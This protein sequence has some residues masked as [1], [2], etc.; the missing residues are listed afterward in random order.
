M[1]SVEFIYDENCPNVERARAVLLKAFSVV[2]Q[3]P[4]WKEWSRSDSNSPDYAQRYGSPSILVNGHDIVASQTLSDASCC[5]IYEGEQ[6][7]FQDVPALETVVAAL[8]NSGTPVRKRGWVTS[9]PTVGAV[10]VPKMVCPSC[11]PALTALASS[12]GISVMEFKPFLTL[13]TFTLL[14]VAVL[15]LSYKARQRRGNGPFYL[16]LLSSAIMLL[17]QYRW[18]STE[19]I[20]V[21]IAM[22]IAASIWN[23]WPKKGAC[24]ACL[25]ETKGET[26]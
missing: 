12:T 7:G 18:Q 14:S 3:T 10:F 25:S 22:L 8:Q 23:A 24:S 4:N 2:K 19:M 9:L 20:Y 15:S 13:F 11:I 5:R 26:S 21:G 1:N 16:G 6:G 17:G